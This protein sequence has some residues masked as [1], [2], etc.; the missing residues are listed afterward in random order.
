MLDFSL[1]GT[2]L[3]R[4]ARLTV[5]TL[6]VGLFFAVPAYMFYVKIEDQV[7]SDSR[8]QAE[9]IATTVA[10]FVEQDIISYRKLVIMVQRGGTDYNEF[11]YNVMMRTLQE[12]QGDV[13]AA[14]VYT[15]K[16]LTDREM[17]YI[18]D[19]TDRRSGKY[20]PMG[21]RESVPAAV[22]EAQRTR[23]PTSNAPA[24]LHHFEHEQCGCV[25]TGYAPIEDHVTETVVGVVGVD[26][27]TKHITDLL[28]DVLFV[29]FSGLFVMIPVGVYFVDRII[30]Q[31]QESQRTDSMTKLQNKQAFNERIQRKIRE[32][33]RT[34]RPFS[35]IVMDVDDFKS[36]NDTYGHLTGD[37]ALL[38]VADAI[39]GS[40]RSGDTGFRC[41]GDEFCVL[42][43][44]VGKEGAVSVAE[45]IQKK[46]LLNTMRS[47]SGGPISLSL[48]MGISDWSPGVSVQELVQQ[49]DDAMYQSKRGGKNRISVWGDEK[50]PLFGAGEAQGAFMG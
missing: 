49:A 42:L 25:V 18:F 19:G 1:Y 41:G 3:N 5:L 38:F 33:R 30:E 26:Y 6:L 40:I 17:M 4:I 48:S 31:R 29:L 7:V 32:S 35:I 20:S 2:K 47:E 8:R 37:K 16:I 36:V 24:H 14:Y 21:S 34:G 27:T 22:L 9:R 45:R 23:R 11:Y 44:G 43:P 12:I 46:I 10:R 15:V 39:R 50:S 13:G 28:R